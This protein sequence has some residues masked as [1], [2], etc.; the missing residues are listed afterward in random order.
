VGTIHD[1]LVVKYSSI[2]QRSGVY[3]GDTRNSAGDKATSPETN[4]AGVAPQ[5]EVAGN[6]KN[7]C[8]H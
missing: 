3:Y 6:G 8:H 1:V 2:H 5:S 7:E 4:E